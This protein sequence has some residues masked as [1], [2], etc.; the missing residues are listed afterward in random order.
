RE[1]AEASHIVLY[2]N[3]AN[4]RKQP[5]NGRTD[6]VVRNVLKSNPTLADPKVVGIDRYLEIPNPKDPP[7]LL[8]F[9]DVEKGKIVPYRGIVARPSLA[10]YVRGLL[11]I[12]AKDHVAL[13]RYCFDYLEHE[14]PEVA[15]DAF[16]VFDRA[17]D[18]DIQRAARTLSAAKLRRWITARRTPESRLHLYGYLLGLCGKSKMDAPLLRKVLGRLLSQTRPPR[19]DGLLTGYTLLD[20]KAGW[21]CTMSLLGNSSEEFLSR[22]QAL[23]SVR[24]FYLT[25]PALITEK[26]VLDAL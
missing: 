26:D 22:Y 15:R 2:V 20:P 10:M 17:A 8:V 9:A 25:H 14:D 1:E 21:A 6:L 13:M 3:L 12:K 18:R 5:G 16:T 7:R 19:I 11:K 4:A 24:Y 23:R